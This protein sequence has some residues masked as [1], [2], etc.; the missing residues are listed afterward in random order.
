MLDLRDEDGMIIELD[1]GYCKQEPLN[2]DLASGD[3]VTVKDMV[4]DD[5][6]DKNLSVF[7]EQ[8]NR[9]QEVVAD[10]DYKKMTEILDIESFARYFVVNEFVANPDAYVTSFFMYKNG[11]DDKIH[12]GPAWD[13]DSA[14]GNRR[15]GD[16]AMNEGFYAPETVMARRWNAFG[17][18]HYDEVTGEWIVETEDLAVSK[19]MYN[20]VEIPEFWEE[21]KR[22]YRETLLGRRDEV[23]AY[24]QKR[25]GRIRNAAMLDGE[26]WGKMDFDDAIR[27]LNWWVD[28][29]FLTLDRVLGEKIQLPMKES[30]M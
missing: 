24:I 26:K 23:L 8:I 16:G 12:A 14:F 15:W 18:S 7:I 30:V 13:F 21:V 1:N 5:N 9:A 10:G 6:M 28:Q 27:Y 25:S 11:V 3:C 20:M 17:K 4:T 19:M 29:R 22:V 2:I